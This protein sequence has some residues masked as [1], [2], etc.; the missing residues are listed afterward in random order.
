[1]LAA[2]V[3]DGPDGRIRAPGFDGPSATPAV[4]QMGEEPNDR[5]L[6]VFNTYYERPLKY[7]NTIS[8]KKKL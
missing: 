2:V 5:R 7:N 1:V 4:A 6:D 3:R 8:F